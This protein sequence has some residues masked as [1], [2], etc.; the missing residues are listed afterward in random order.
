MSFATADLDTRFLLG[1]MITR[2]PEDGFD[3]SD[4]RPEV[5]EAR[6][7]SN[8]RGPAS[9]DLFALCASAETPH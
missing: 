2:L 7:R 3:V 4:G 6:K 1:S 5:A 9:N 8:R